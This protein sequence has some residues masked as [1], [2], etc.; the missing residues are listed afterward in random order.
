MRKIML[1][2]SVLLLTTACQNE[3]LVLDNENLVPDG[4]TVASN[5]SLDIYMQQ[6]DKGNMISNSICFRN[7]KFVLD[8]SLEDALS[9]GIDHSMYENQ[10]KLIENINKSN[11]KL[12]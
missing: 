7:G 10:I 9:I 1:F 8:L 4:V 2:L 12:K 5:D 6:T 3:E 11:L